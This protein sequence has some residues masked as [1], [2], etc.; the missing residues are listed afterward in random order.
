MKTMKRIS[1]TLLAL[2][3]AG[4]ACRLEAQNIT[5]EELQ[6]IAII[7]QKVMMPMRDGI[8][9]CTDIYRPKTKEPVPVIFERTPYNFNAYADGKMNT[10]SFRKIYNAILRG[11]AYVIQNERG[12]YFSEGDWDILGTPLTDGYDA[13]SWMKNQSMVQWQNRN[14]GLFLHSRVADGCRSARSSIA[15]SYGAN[16]FWSRCW[17]GRTIL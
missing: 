7:D 5:L 12:R 6:K 9:L 14:P 2:L 10:G 13:F 11:Y 17:Q 4:I 15:C 3:F 16:G 1:F 8:R